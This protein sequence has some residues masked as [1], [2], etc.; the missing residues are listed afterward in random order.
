MRRVDDAHIVYVTFRID[1]HIHS[2]LASGFEATKFRR[3][4]RHHLLHGGCRLF[5]LIA[6][7]INAR[8]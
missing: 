2:R 1:D 8:E 7:K 4:D 6:F 3:V 5:D